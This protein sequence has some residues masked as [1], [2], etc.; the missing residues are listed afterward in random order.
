MSSVGC[1]PHLP[2]N[3][4]AGVDEIVL[5]S[6]GYIVMVCPSIRGSA[7]AFGWSF[8]SH[9]NSLDTNV[10]YFASLLIVLRAIVLLTVTKGMKQ[11]ES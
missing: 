7:L 9:G 10:W 3:N 8:V 2:L 1:G 5:V 11:R 4:F 6:D